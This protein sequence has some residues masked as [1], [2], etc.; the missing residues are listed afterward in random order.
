MLSLQELI[1]LLCVLVFFFAGLIYLFLST[2]LKRREGATRSNEK[3]AAKSK[4]RDESAPIPALPPLSMDS[5]TTGVVPAPPLK[6]TRRFPTH[7]PPR[8]PVPDFL[9][10]CVSW[11]REHSDAHSEFIFRVAG[12]SEK[13]RRLRSGELQ[14]KD[15]TDARDDVTV[16]QC[17][18]L[19]LKE[20]ASGS[21][22]PRRARA[23]F[24]ASLEG[25]DRNPAFSGFVPPRRA[26]P[27]SSSMTRANDLFVCGPAAK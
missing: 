12:A 22:V 20:L 25:N 7:V 5:L 13:I 17:T 16:A 9:V 2:F 4:V 6:P 15:L 3:V 8:L 14:L 1:I 24:T 27:L 19:F 21:L 26:L 10:Q 11:L 18:K 23:H